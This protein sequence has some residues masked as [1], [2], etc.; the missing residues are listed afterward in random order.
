MLESMERAPGSELRRADRIVEPVWGW[1]SFASQGWDEIDTAAEGWFAS[2]EALW[3]A[4]TS[5]VEVAI[6]EPGALER[7]VAWL[8]R[9]AH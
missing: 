8:R 1:D 4:D 3:R 7:L 2:G 9:L 5:V 6:D